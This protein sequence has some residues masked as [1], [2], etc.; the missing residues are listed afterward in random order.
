[1]VDELDEL[2]REWLGNLVGAHDLAKIDTLVALGVRFRWDH[3]PCGSLR[4][5]AVNTRGRVVAETTA[6]IGASRAMMVTMT[7]DALGVSAMERPH[8][9]G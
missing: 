1:M 5:Q 8:G 4:F 6:W 3:A 9:A 2:N 7:L